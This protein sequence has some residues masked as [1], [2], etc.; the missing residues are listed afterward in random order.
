MFELFNLIKKII[1]N[2]GQFIYSTLDSN[3]NFLYSSDGN[4]AYKI[5]NSHLYKCSICAT[6]FYNIECHCENKIK[7]DITLLDYLTTSS[8]YIK[9]YSLI[10]SIVFSLSRPNISTAPSDLLKCYFSIMSE[11]DCIL[12]SKDIN[13]PVHKSMI[14][15]RCNNLYNN[16]DSICVNLSKNAV[17]LLFNYI[18]KNIID[19]FSKEVLCE[20]I[21]FAK[22]Y[23]IKNLINTIK[24]S[25]WDNKKIKLYFAL[26]L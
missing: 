18:Y 22:K 9:E 6:I 3:T 24:S 12:E 26:E 2:D 13:I 15:M 16:S 8:L 19:N 23:D 14:Q 20:L 21:E 7:N 1:T 25:L 10:N 17:M 11:F 4:K 5:K